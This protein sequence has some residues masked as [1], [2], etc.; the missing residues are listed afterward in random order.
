VNKDYYFKIDIFKYITKKLKKE[1]FIF[2]WIF[3][4]ECDST[5][6]N[7]GY[8]LRRVVNI[9]FSIPY[10]IISDCRDFKDRIWMDAV[11]S[12]CIYKVYMEY[13]GE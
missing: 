8:E 11:L 9:I 12:D 6:Y 5:L 3:S 10:N 13:K 4:K 7:I 1:L 2:N